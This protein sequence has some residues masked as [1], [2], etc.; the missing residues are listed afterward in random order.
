MGAFRHGKTWRSVRYTQRKEER[1]FLIKLLDVKLS[2]WF[3]FKSKR[4]FFFFLKLNTL[5]NKLFDI[6]KE[7]LFILFFLN[8]YHLLFIWIPQVECTNKIILLNLFDSHNLAT[9]YW[10]NYNATSSYCKITHYNVL[11]LYMRTLSQIGPY[12]SLIEYP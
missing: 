10:W 12:W 6:R 4:G 3:K 7:N 2:L 5:F 11:G 9:W 8:S 1:C